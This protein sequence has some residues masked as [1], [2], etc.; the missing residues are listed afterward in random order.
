MLKLSRLQNKEKRLVAGLMSGTSVDGIDAG[1]VWIDHSRAKTRYQLI[2]FLTYPYPEKIRKN[3]LE[4]SQPSFQNLDEVLRLDFIL[5]E[6]FAEAFLALLK[7]SRISP[8]KV[9]LIGS[10]GQTIRHL[11]KEVIRDNHKVKATLQIG[12]PAVIAA[13]TGVVTIGDFRVGD[14]AVGGEGAPLTPLIHFLLFGKKGFPQAVLNIG[15]IANITFLPSSNRK[16]E[17]F[18]FD[19]G[20]GNCLVDQLMRRI[21]NKGFDKDGKSALQGKVYSELLYKFKKHNYFKRKPPKST[22]KEDFGKNLVEG[23]IN[24]AEK[25]NIGK[26][27]LIATV[28]KLTPWSVYES[29]ERFIEPIKRIKRLLVAGGGVHNLYFLKR[30]KELFYPIEVLSTEKMGIN[31]DALESMA[32]A[33]LADLAISEKFGNLPKVTG[34]NKEQILGKIC[35]P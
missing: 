17:V 6:C 16:E 11:P 9:D 20:P 8:K 28:S 33:I 24:S 29:Y 35:L 26:L 27:D 3:I 25:L 15:G 18:A 4:F 31:P 14:V 13:K 30:L 1:L 19:T 5:G 12:E 2:D 7:K 23:I 34:A 32:F 21:F 10:H 22:G